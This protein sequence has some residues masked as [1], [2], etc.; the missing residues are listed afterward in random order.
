MAEQAAQGAGAGHAVPLIAQAAGGQA[1]GV[2]RLALL[3]RGL[4]GVRGKTGAAIGGGEHAVFVQAGLARGGS[5]RQWPLLGAC[6]FEHVPRQTGDVQIAPSGALAVLIPHRLGALVGM[7]GGVGEQ[8]RLAGAQAGLQLVCKLHR[9]G[10]VVARLAGGGHGRAHAGDAAFAVGHRASLLAPGGGG[11][12]QV[13]IGTGGGGGKGFLHH[14]KLGALQCAAHGG[15]VWHALRGVGA[16]NPQRL[17]L[18]IGGGLE[19]LHGRLARFGW[20][21]GHA[22]E[23]SY[24]GAVLGVGQVAV[25]AEQIGKATH[26]APAH[27]VGLAGQAE[28]ARAG[29]ADLCGGQVQVDERCVLGRAAAALVQ[30]LAVQAERGFG[31]RKPLGGGGQVGHA[32]TAGLRHTLGRVVAYQGLERVKARGVCGD[33][34]GVRPSLPQHQVQHAVEQHHV[35]AGLEGQEQVGHAGGVGAARVGHDDLHA[36]VGGA[37]VFN[38]AEQDGVRPCRVAAHDE[39][40]LCVLHVVVA[41][42]RRIGAQGL[43]V[44]RH[45]AAHAQ[46]RVGVDVVR[47]DQALGQLVEDVVVLGEQLPAHVEAHGVG[48]VLLDDV[49]ELV[50]G[51]AQGGVPRQGLGNAAALRAMLG[52]QEP[53]LQRDGAA[54]REVQGRSLGTQAAKVGGVVRVTAHAGD[55]GAIAFDDHAAAY[56]AVGA[57]G[58][59]FFH[60][61][62][63]RCFWGSGAY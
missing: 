8:R 2:T 39:Q 54:G 59:G 11:Q 22:P 48:T 41:R 51:H 12:Q 53:G 37:R 35:A 44:A 25:G 31:L 63:F 60:G 10:P 32:E 61:V 7:L 28:R 40:A 29:L 1:E 19:H 30:A 33:V 4:P 62:S 21:I 26:F 52:L 23:R 15:L 20:H 16:G 18:A 17:D 42:G 55:L 24:F 6:R 36:G 45:R 13:G 38:A 5:L 34:L 57:G 43:L 27:G 56:A 9:N 3:G 49:G 47:A 58:M 46:A 14:H 50:S